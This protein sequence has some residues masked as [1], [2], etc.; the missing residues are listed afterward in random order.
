[1][2]DWVDIAKSL[3]VVVAILANKNNIL[4]E[5]T[6]D[7]ALHVQVYRVYL[8]SASTATNTNFSP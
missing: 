2:G 7:C 6:V 4:N 1:M 3:W 5:S 8:H